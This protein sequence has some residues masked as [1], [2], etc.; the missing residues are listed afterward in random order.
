VARLKR[1]CVVG[2]GLLG[3]SVALAARRANLAESVIGFSPSSGARAKALG[4]ID[5]SADTIEAAVDGADAIVLAAP[6][7]AIARFVAEPPSTLGAVAWIT[8]VA[9]TKG[10]IADLCL[11]A[12]TTL[13]ARFVP[14][15]PIAG[16]HEVG[17]EAARVDLFEGSRVVVTPVATNAVEAIEGVN[18]FWQALGASTL[19]M[20]AHE[21]DRRYALVSHLPHVISF[22]LARVLAQQPD[23]A[24]L[25]EIG[26]GSL[27]DLTR[28]AASDPALWT[29]ISRENQPALKEALVMM[30]QA[31][32][33][34]ELALDAGDWSALKAQFAQ[35]QH[36]KLS[37]KAT[38]PS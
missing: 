20:E 22:A 17:P 8:D 21:H 25:A 27:R 15:H 30:R 26:G 34:A 19:V 5:D 14:A 16:S 29:D 36:W 13:Q 11:Q 31:L 18:H 28:I 38:Q 33:E 1:L 12:N 3:G 35:G 10:R 2:V 9:S 24:L 37:A 23:A 4:L 32:A 7:S 6:P